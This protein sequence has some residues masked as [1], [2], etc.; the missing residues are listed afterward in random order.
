MIDIMKQGLGQ[1]RPNKTAFAKQDGGAS[2]QQVLKKDY[3]ER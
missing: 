2:P 3:S 1:A